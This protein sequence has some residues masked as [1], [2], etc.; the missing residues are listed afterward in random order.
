MFHCCKQCAGTCC[1]SHVPL[2]LEC[3]H[4]EACSHQLCIHLWVVSWLRVEV[5]RNSFSLYSVDS[6]T[7]WCYGHSFDYPFN[8]G[9]RSSFSIHWPD[10]FCSYAGECFHCRVILFKLDILLESILFLPLH[11]CLF[12][13]L[14]AWWMC[15]DADLSH[16]F[17]QSSWCVLPLQPFLLSESIAAYYLCTTLQGAHLNLS[18][19]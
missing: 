7:H 11:C 19:L 17:I 4:M 13:L 3:L 2:R 1:S 15:K 6:T 14:Q 9:S 12:F 8:I 16:A 5:Q 18:W 10:P